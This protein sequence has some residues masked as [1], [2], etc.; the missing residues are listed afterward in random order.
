MLK[1]L[2]D[3]LEFW[4]GEPLSSESLYHKR[5]KLWFSKNPGFD[6][7]ICDRFLPVY[8]WATSAS[9]ENW[10]QSARGCL[11]LVIVFDQFPRNMFRGEAKAFATDPQARMVAE[12]ALDRGFD[13]HLPPIQRLFL[14]LPFE[15]SER[16]SDQDQ[17]VTLFEQLSLT[18]PE[19]RDNFDYAI[20]HRQVIERFG[21]FPHRNAALKRKNTP[22]EEEF[23]KQPGS[24]F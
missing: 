24:S 10:Q 13:H 23:L 4:F 8:E 1:Y 19:L 16:L 17:S 11:A 18:N 21:R 6:Q 14:Y 22:E 9:T 15:H 5:R 12:G 7:M 20:R 3:V 2:D